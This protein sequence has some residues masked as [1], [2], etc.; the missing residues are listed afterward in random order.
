VLKERKDQGVMRSRNSKYRQYN[1]K[2]RKNKEVIRSVILSTDTTM[3]KR[4]D[5]WSSSTYSDY[6]SVFCVW[7]DEWLR[8]CFWKVRTIP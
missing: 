6:C 5:K 2:E 4:E 8:S 3:E 1:G 7:G